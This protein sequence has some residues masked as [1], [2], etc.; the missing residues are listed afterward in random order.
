[1]IEDE[2]IKFLCSWLETDGWEIKSVAL[3]RER[4]DDIR[5]VRGG[6][7]L[8]V[9]AKGAKGNPKNHNVVR[10]EFDSGQIKNH[11]GEAIVKALE[12]KTRNPK[13]KI[14]IAHPATDKILKIVTPI[15]RQLVPVEISF[16]F[17]SDD[18]TINWA[19]APFEIVKVA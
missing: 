6:Q 16:A 8:L 10:P 2:V 4:G 17:V 5:A 14:V 19:G 18:G 15:A 3:G 11:L 9:E 7:V 12:L 13:A 1:M